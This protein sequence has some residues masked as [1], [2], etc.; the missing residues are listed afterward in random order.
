[1]PSNSQEYADWLAM[2]SVDL[3]VNTLSVSQFFNPDYSK[4]FNL[5]YPVGDTIRVPYPDRASIRNGLPYNPDGINRRHA[6]VAFDEPFGTDFE[7][8]SVEERLRTPRGKSKFSKEILEPRM[9]QIAQEIDSRCA[10]YAYINAASLIGAL[11]TNPS[12]YDA[13]SGAARQIMQ[14]LACPPSGERAL[15]VPPSVM[16]AVKASN[17]SLNNPVSDI[18][19]QFRS[20]IVQH[21]DGFEWYESMSLYRHTAGTWAGAVTVTTTQTGTAAINSLALTCT[22]N[23]TFK[24]GDKFSIANVLPVNP[25]TRRTFGTAAKTFTCLGNGSGSDVTGASSAAT[26]TFSPAIYGPG[27]VHQNVDALPVA[28][29]ALTLWPGT[30]SP[31]GKSGTVGLALHRDAFALVGVEL[32]EPKSSS[33]EL[34]SQKRDPDSG[35]AVRYIRQFDGRASKMIN[36]FDVMI[37]YGT[38]YNDSCAIAVACG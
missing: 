2:E 34:V 10:Q 6:T 24:V 11:G 9:A 30:T 7:L 5:K 17:L 4:E 33:V 3:L 27:S 28:A 23:D 18:S 35:I 15:I 19:K 14:E 37:G 13:T 20:G 31:N 38:F 12:T 8:D 32:D 22:T 26:I 36:R 29:A 25:M 16:R 1:M 21:A